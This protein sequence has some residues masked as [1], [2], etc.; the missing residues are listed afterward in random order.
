VATAFNSLVFTGHSAPG[1]VPVNDCQPYGDIFIDRITSLSDRPSL[2]H[3]I[4]YFH[5]SVSLVFVPWT[6]LFRPRPLRTA[7]MGRCSE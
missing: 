4:C 2:A 3:G 6:E 1:S 5:T 7:R